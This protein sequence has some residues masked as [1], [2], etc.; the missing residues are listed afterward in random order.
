MSGAS[1]FENVF[2]PKEKSQRRHLGHDASCINLAKFFS[3]NAKTMAEE[4]HHSQ[5]SPT[6][7]SRHRAVAASISLASSSMSFSGGLSHDKSRG[8]SDRI[9]SG[10][11]EIGS[12]RPKSILRGSNRNR[13]KFNQSNQNVSGPIIGRRHSS[14]SG[15]G[16]NDNIDLSSLFGG[17]MPDIHGCGSDGSD[18]NYDNNDNGNK[19]VSRYN[20]SNAIS[21]TTIKGKTAVT[22]REVSVAT[23]HKDGSYTHEVCK[24]P[25]DDLSCKDDKNNVRIDAFAS[26]RENE[27]HCEGVEHALHSPDYQPNEQNVSLQ[28][29]RVISL[30]LAPLIPCWAIPSPQAATTPQQMDQQ[31]QHLHKHKWK[32]VKVSSITP[33]TVPPSPLTSAHPLTSRHPCKKLGSSIDSTEDTTALAKSN[34]SNK[35]SPSIIRI[36]DLPWTDIESRRKGFYTG[37][38]NRH[39]YPHGHGIFVSMD[40]DGR[41]DGVRWEGE[42]CNGHFISSSLFLSSFRSQRLTSFSSSMSVGDAT[43]VTETRTSTPK[44][45]KQ[46]RRHSLKTAAEDHEVLDERVINRRISTTTASSDFE[47]VSSVFNRF[48]GTKMKL[49]SGSMSKQKVVRRLSDGTTDGVE[50]LWQENDHFLSCMLNANCTDTSD[51]ATSTKSSQQSFSRVARVNSAESFHPNQSNPYHDKCTNGCEDTRNGVGPALSKQRRRHSTG[52]SLTVKEC[53]GVK[54]VKW[55]SK[56]FVMYCPGSLP[57][58]LRWDPLQHYNNDSSCY[59]PSHNRHVYRLGESIQSPHDIMIFPTEKEMMQRINSL[60]VHDFAFVRRSNGTWTYAILADRGKQKVTSASLDGGVPKVSEA[61]NENSSNL[62]KEEF[63]MF[64]M[65]E[66]RS[67]KVIWKSQWKNCIRCIR[68]HKERKVNCVNY[69]VS[70]S[71]GKGENKR[72]E[73]QNLKSMLKKYSPQP[74]TSSANLTPNLNLNDIVAKNEGLIVVNGDGSHPCKNHAAND[75][76]NV[77]PTIDSG[78]I[79]GRFESYN[80]YQGSEDKRHEIKKSAA[81]KV[82]K[83]NETKVSNKDYNRSGGK[84]NTC[85]NLPSDCVSTDGSSTSS[86]SVIWV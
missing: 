65:N 61:G 62:E 41:D 70:N 2:P 51:T 34:Q 60:K 18:E 22:F 12:C 6:S 19:K 74:S 43:A 78:S 9:G 17:S 14:G 44:N 38:V 21:S 23:L 24:I 72:N 32:D 56:D 82:E 80:T 50:C 75:G 31:E 8:H 76:C 63:M 58:E 57:R 10:S 33:R 27:N 25:F 7:P 66:A 30:P 77:V 73:N 42:W 4:R 59:D 5:H 64:V 52:A 13:A 55:H 68:G 46:R 81:N 35:P 85:C 86:S 67:V 39:I 45:C 29:E 1:H 47:E 84:L 49:D 71:K 69:C 28:S 40:N 48:K 26:E 11:T 79:E 83:G 36:F 15:G 53:G 37:A 20:P 16:E 3:V 54:D